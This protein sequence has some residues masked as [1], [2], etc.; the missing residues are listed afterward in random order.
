MLVLDCEEANELILY[1]GPRSFL[2]FC[3]KPGI[4]WVT[5]KVKTS[6]F[7][8]VAKR[9][10]VDM[11]RM[12]KIDGNLSSERAKEPASEMAWQYTAGKF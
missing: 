9:L 10:I 1:T 4:N 6:G 12:L 11:T 2:S 7:D 3:S 8:S 5:S